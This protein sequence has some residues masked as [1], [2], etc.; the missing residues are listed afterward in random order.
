MV[1]LAISMGI[2][3]AWYFGQQLKDGLS[4]LV[5]IAISGSTLALFTAFRTETIRWQDNH[6]RR[7]DNSDKVIDYYNNSVRELVIAFMVAFDE[8]M[9]VHPELNDQ[10]EFEL[11]TASRLGLPK[12]LHLTDKIAWLLE[13]NSYLEKADVLSAIASE[14]SRL[15]VSEKYQWVIEQTLVNSSLEHVKY[16]IVS[17]KEVQNYD[18]QR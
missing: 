1:L 11:N 8:V 16:L 12:I 14:L 5:G 3:G 17:L 18:R 9:A 15:L 2:A 7:I 13:Q 4:Q 6:M 10:S